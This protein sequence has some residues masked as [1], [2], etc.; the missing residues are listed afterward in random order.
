LAIPL[1]HDRGTVWEVDLNPT[2]GREMQ[3]VRPCLIVSVDAISPTGLRLIVPVTSLTQRKPDALLHVSLAVVDT[4]DAQNGGLDH[5]SF[6]DIFQLRCLAIERF[7]K[8]LC[9]VKQD[10]VQ[11][12]VAQ[13]ATVIGVDVEMS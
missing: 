2:K 11:E 3:K 10:K 7:K 13:I 9:R 4:Y 5:D 12:V 8:P 6:V 1:L